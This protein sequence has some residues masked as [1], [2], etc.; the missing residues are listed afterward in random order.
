MRSAE[1]DARGIIDTM[2]VAITTDI[3]IWTRYDRYATSVPTSISPL[4][5]RGAP[6]QS[7]ATL[8]EVDEEVDRREHRRHQPAAA[9]RDHGEVGVG[10]LEP[11]RFLR[12]ADEGAHDANAGDLLAQHAVHLVDPLLHEAE[13]GNHERHDRAED[14][15]GRPAS[16]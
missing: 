12:L 11:L 5:T 8:D 1:T 4:F 2:K 13:R 9:Q 6:I 3:R 16:R 7:T 15:R 14:D 10:G